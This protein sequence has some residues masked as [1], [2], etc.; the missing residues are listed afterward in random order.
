MS[1]V[2]KTVFLNYIICALFGGFLEYIAP[3]KNRKTLRVIVVAIMLIVS[4]SPILKINFDFSDISASYEFD[5]TESYD[6]LMHTANLTEKKIYNEVREILINLEIDEY[7]IYVNTTVEIDE[8]AVYLDSVKI[9]IAEEFA[10]K[11]PEIKKR[12]KVEY[13]TVLIVEK[14]V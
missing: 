2:I 10:D 5:E 12:V 11:I 14:M 8:N 3:E 6:A 4:L 7:E 9:Q 13:Q 1:E